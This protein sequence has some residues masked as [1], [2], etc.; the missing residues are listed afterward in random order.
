VEGVDQCTY[1]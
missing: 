1:L